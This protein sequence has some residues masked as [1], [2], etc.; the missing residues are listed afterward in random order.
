MLVDLAWARICTMPVLYMK[1]GGSTFK[2]KKKKSDPF[3]KDQLSE[4]R[5][6]TSQE[7]TNSELQKRHC[8]ELCIC[9]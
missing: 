3:K 6:S 9:A 8:M 7:I 2:K 4:S 1:C 5:V